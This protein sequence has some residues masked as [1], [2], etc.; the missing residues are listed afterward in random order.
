MEFFYSPLSGNSARVA[1]ALHEAG[2]P[3]TPHALNLLAG[4]TRSPAYLAIN[5]MG[6]VP[7]LIDG[8]VHL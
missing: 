8:A 1:F 7:A 2:V 3:Y 6:K 4:E 5:P